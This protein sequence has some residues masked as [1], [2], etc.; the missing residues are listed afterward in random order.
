MDTCDEALLIERARRGEQ[1]AF[2]ELVRL[3]QGPVRAL[4]RRLSGG[5]HALADDLAQETFLRAWLSLPR[6]R[7]EARFGT[8]LYR[9]A[10]NAY[11]MHARR[12]RRVV[13]F[14][15][16]PDTGEETAPATPAAGPDEVARS[17][18]RQALRILKPAE[19]A[20]IV[21]CYY[22][23]LSHAEAA[24][25]LGY[26]LGTLKSHLRRALRK[27]QD[28]LGESVAKEGLR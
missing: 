6:F 9:I 28:Y 19:R 13:E 21:Q 12:A 20:A 2:A 26:P 22:L 18:V 11:L 27:L 14:P 10:Y 17:E 1:R 3:Y 7:N 23:D 8:W 25:A 5:Q 24:L 4:L 15:L 16:D